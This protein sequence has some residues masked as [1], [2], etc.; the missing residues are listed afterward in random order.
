MAYVGAIDAYKRANAR[1][2]SANYFRERTGTIIE[3]GKIKLAWVT[4]NAT[5]PAYTNKDEANFWYDRWDAF[6]ELYDGGT[7]SIHTSPL[8]L[9]M[10]TQNELFMSAIIGMSCSIV[11]SFLV[12]LATTRN[13]RIAI[14]AVL[15][16]STITI[17]FLGTI[18]AM[19]WELGS[20]ESIF[21]IIVVG[22]AVDYTAHLLHA[23]NHQ[24]SETR[25]E[26]TQGAF[27]EI[28][29]SV[30]SGAI[31]TLLA[32]TPLFLCYFWFFFQFGVFIFLV[33]LAAIIVAVFLLG[34]L[35]LE[36]GPED[37]SS[38]KIVEV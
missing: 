31:T 38:P 29:I 27:A 24:T 8:Y 26:R 34:P 10:V 20:N 22:L 16:I 12:I 9:F 30:V 17:I 15:S 1:V 2:Y 23:Y 4:F 11:V 13:L 35:M 33:I 7:N 25:H 21:L 28:G 19:G 5:Y 36:I 3:D 6:H 37:K 18:P 14:L 32:A